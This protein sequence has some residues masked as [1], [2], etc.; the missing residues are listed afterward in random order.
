MQ[1][2]FHQIISDIE[3]NASASTDNIDDIFSRL[4]EAGLTSFGQLLISLPSK[5][6]PAISDLL[7]SF[8]SEQVQR[9]WTGSSGPA[10]LSQSLDF[11]RF[12]STAYTDITRKSLQNKRILDYGCGYGRLSRLFYYYTN[13]NNLHGV[14]PWVESIKEC[15]AHGLDRN[16]HLSEFLPENLPVKGKFDLIFAFSVFTHL[17]EDYARKCLKTLCNYLE[18]DGVLI[19]TIRPVEFWDY[20]DSHIGMK[21]NQNEVEDLKTAHNKTN[22][23]F[24]SQPSGIDS[25]Y[26]DTSM[27]IEWI[28]NNLPE[29]NINL[30]D[31]S[32][33]DIY[34][35]YVCLQL[36]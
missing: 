6:F 30:I 22:Y 12:C 7:P 32:D 27:S 8:S 24:R 29:C 15:K 11:V 16:Y 19:I 2:T 25:G 13:Y 20:R 18:K 35:T 28:K 21:L 31:Y 4:R 23:A 17:D 14:D 33:K 3:A 1:S 5:E 10:L 36:K 9:N 34:Q 26:G